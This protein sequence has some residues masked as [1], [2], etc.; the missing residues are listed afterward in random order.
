LPYSSVVIRFESTA[1]MPNYLFEEDEPMRMPDTRLPFTLPR[2]FALL[3]VAMVLG[4]SA[5]AVSGASPAS[6]QNPW[7]QIVYGNLGGFGSGYG[8]F[9]G[10][11]G[12]NGFGYGLGGFTYPTT[13]TTNGYIT[14]SP[15]LTLQPANPTGTGISVG[16]AWVYCPTPGSSTVWVT[17]AQAAGLRC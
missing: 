5:L 15:A 14:N 1:R 13:Y 12:Y 3:L 17:S 10:G 16:V 2:R 6:A 7:L 11:L 9:Y 8:G 4:V